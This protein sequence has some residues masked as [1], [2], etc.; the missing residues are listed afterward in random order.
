MK[1]CI[2]SPRWQQLDSKL[3]NS[4]QQTIQHV[5]VPLSIFYIQS[6]AKK[7]DAPWRCLLEDHGDL[8]CDCLR[9][10]FSLSEEHSLFYFTH[11]ASTA[12]N[13]INGQ[14]IKLLLTFSPTYSLS[15][16]ISSKKTVKKGILHFNRF[17]FKLRGVEASVVKSFGVRDLCLRR[18]HTGTNLNT[19]TDLLSHC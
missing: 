7:P 13:T 15:E 14:C 18:P 5:T 12:A 17:V 1:V 19:R 2:F 3:P 11:L 4:I 8:G 6:M 9:L 10:A 16:T